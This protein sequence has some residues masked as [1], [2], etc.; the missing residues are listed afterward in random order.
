MKV[1]ELR[2]GNIVLNKHGLP[3]RIEHLS[4]HHTEELLKLQVSISTDLINHVSPEDFMGLPLDSRWLERLSF[5]DKGTH[6]E[7]GEIKLYP[8]APGYRVNEFFGSQISFL[9]QLQNLLYVID[10]PA[11][12]AIF[13]NP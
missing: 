2:I 10:G 1:N 13:I 8:K 9:H 7:K 12:K 5:A 6:W 11:E 4:A 3:I